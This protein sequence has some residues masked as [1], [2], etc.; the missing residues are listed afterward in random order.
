MSVNPLKAFY[1]LVRTRSL[2]IAGLIFLL[3]TEPEQEQHGLDRCASPTGLH[4]CRSQV[5][6]HN[7]PRLCALAWPHL[8]EYGRSPPLALNSWLE[9]RRPVPFLLRIISSRIT[10]SSPASPRTRRRAAGQWLLQRAYGFISTLIFMSIHL[11]LAS[12]R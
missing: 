8:L 6:L 9:Y 10:D 11:I 12:A 4:I 1:R 3:H 7:L 2:I 5:T